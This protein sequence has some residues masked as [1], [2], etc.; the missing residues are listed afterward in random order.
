LSLGVPHQPRQQSKTPKGKKTERKR[1]REER[2]GGQGWEGEGRGEK[3][4]EE[5]KGR[6]TD[7]I[8]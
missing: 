5:R 6:E 4:K 1:G 2:R 3:T 8:W 7:T